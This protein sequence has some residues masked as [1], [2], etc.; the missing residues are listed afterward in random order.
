M[1]SLKICSLASTEVAMIGIKIPVKEIRISSTVEGTSER[2][3]EIRIRFPAPVRAA[4]RPK[5]APVK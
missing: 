1:F 5:A 3:P 4:E 2:G